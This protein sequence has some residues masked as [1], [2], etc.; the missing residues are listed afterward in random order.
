MYWHREKRKEQEDGSTSSTQT[1]FKK[2]D[3]ATYDFAFF[4][5][6]GHEEKQ[7]LRGKEGKE[8]TNEVI[9]FN[10]RFKIISKTMKEESTKLIV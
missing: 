1:I 7:N 3:R 8:E 10:K 2:K 9:I 5:I 6:C 4:S